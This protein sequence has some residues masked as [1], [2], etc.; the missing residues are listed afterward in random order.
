MSLLTLVRATA[1]AATRFVS[2][3]PTDHEY[4]TDWLRVL[5]LGS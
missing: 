2:S 1:L 5:P 4:A 3:G